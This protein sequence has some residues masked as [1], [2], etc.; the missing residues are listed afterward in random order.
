MHLTWPQFVAQ[1]NK[2]DIWV[3][4]SYTYI[5]HVFTL[6]P[7]GKIPQRLDRGWWHIV[8]I[9]QKNTGVSWNATIHWS[10]FV[11]KLEILWFQKLNFGNTSKKKRLY[12]TGGFPWDRCRFRHVPISVRCVWPRSPRMCSW[13][14]MAPFDPMWRRCTLAMGL[15][16][17]GELFHKRM[18]L[19]IGNWCYHPVGVITPK[20]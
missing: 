8:N 5:I 11:G 7:S 20:W 6:E 2:P 3:E 1:K 10:I 14:P 15:Q 18:A 4:V 16:E 13:P 17:W 19:Q 9:T 12:F